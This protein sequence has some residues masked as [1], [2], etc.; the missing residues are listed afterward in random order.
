MYPSVTIIELA[1]LLM[2]ILPH[3][4]QTD[5]NS[6]TDIEFPESDMLQI[7]H[8]FQHIVMFGVL[9][10]ANLLMQDCRKNIQKISQIFLRKNK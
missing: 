5:E 3:S 2:K 9:R 4:R 6:L 7:H 1:E 10:S 8:I